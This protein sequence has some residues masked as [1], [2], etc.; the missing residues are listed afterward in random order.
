MCRNLWSVR[1]IYPAHHVPAPIEHED[2]QMGQSRTMMYMKAVTIG[3]NLQSARTCAHAHMVSMVSR[4]NLSTRLDEAI[5][6]FIRRRRAMISPL[7]RT[8]MSYTLTALTI[9]S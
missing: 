4:R 1:V 2:D 6:D 9:T 7:M 5:S 3:G 8:G